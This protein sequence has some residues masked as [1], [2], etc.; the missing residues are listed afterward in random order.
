M[1]RPSTR[2]AAPEE[3]GQDYGHLPSRLLTECLQAG[4]GKEGF[5]PEGVSTTSSSPLRA[6]SPFV[7]LSSHRPS[8]GL[9]VFSISPLV[10]WPRDYASASRYLLTTELP[11]VT[12]CRCLPLAITQEIID[13]LSR[14]LLQKS[15]QRNWIGNRSKSQ[16]VHSS[17]SCTGISK[18]SFTAR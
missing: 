3:N 2:R 17:S 12:S 5:R 1:L 18:L 4:A 10:S 9:L 11:E 14:E 7:L 8:F 16:Q 6:A 15:M 13:V